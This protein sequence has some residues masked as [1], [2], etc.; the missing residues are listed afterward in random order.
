MSDE[1]HGNRMS[2]YSRS[3][4]FHN[5]SLARRYSCLKKLIIIVPYSQP[6]HENASGFY[7]SHTWIG[8]K[9]ISATFFFFQFKNSSWKF[10][11][12]VGNV[13]WFSILTVLPL[14]RIYVSPSII[15]Y[16]YIYINTHTHMYIHSST[17]THRHIFVNW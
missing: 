17:H 14:L 7:F 11:V 5:W 1:G 16:I 2:K 6:Y 13:F 15:I 12:V 3:F 9:T 10:I 4:R 8:G